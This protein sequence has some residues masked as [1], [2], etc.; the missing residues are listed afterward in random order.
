[1][2]G[3]LYFYPGV[4]MTK[5]F[6][7][8]AI[9]AV[10]VVSG[11]GNGDSTP[12]DDGHVPDV[13]DDG[14]VVADTTPPDTALPDTAVPDVGVDTNVEPDTVVVPDDGQTDTS[15]PVDEGRQ[16]DSAGSCPVGVP[17]GAL[18]NQAASCAVLCDD[19]TFVETCLAQADQTVSDGVGALLD[20]IDGSGCA[21]LF[22]GEQV[23]DCVA[24]A[25]S[26]EVGAC[27]VGTLSCRD[28]WGCRKDCDVADPACPMNCVTS[29]T[30][31]AQQE[32]GAYVD[33]IFGVECTTEDMMENGWPT[34]ACESNAR[35][36]CSMPYQACFPP[37]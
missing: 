28:I 6:A 11:C 18:C 34:F 8:L 12:Q 1:M 31:L 26:A 23:A 3:W 37:T 36:Y 9:V 24:T 2:Q 13:V 35:D 32:W 10:F 15:V 19:A 22:V 14:V 30:A 20:C 21:D 29:G 25:C 4:I 17:T 16:P 33:C 5:L 7:S 27:L